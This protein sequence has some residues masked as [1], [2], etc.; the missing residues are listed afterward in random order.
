MAAINKL[1]SSICVDSEI[2]LPYVFA[3][4]A[5]APS[6]SSK[7]TNTCPIGAGQPVTNFRKACKSVCRLKVN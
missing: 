4:I 2:C 7:V 5:S 1:R 3:E 6:S